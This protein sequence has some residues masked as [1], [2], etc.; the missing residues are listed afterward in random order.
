MSDHDRP[1][2][3]A[4]I[5]QCV[6]F[7]DAAQSGRLASEIDKDSPAACEIAALVSEIDRLGI[8]RTA[9]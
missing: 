9:L 3:A 4:T 2:L 5:G 8:G 6:V 1:L 7:V